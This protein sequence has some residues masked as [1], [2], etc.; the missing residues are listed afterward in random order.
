MMME[1]KAR[2]WLQQ[3]REKFGFTQEEVATRAGISRTTY[4]S[5]EQ[6][7]RKPSVATAKKI[8]KALQ[9]KWTIFFE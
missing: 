6:G 1:I 8:A 7:Y 9:F 3:I 4:A 5:I 2:N